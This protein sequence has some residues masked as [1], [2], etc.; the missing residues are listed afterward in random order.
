MVIIFMLAPW[1][2]RAGHAVGTV[3]AVAGRS[4][5]SAHKQF[6]SAPGKVTASYRKCKRQLTD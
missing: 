1:K 2:L 6:V 5:V 3:G 4:W